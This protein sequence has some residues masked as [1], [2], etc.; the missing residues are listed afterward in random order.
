MAERRYW[1]NTVS[2]DHVQN[3]IDGGFTQA[4]HGAATRLRRLGG[5]DEIVFY[6]PRTRFRGGRPLQSFTAIGSIGAGAPYQVSMTD[7]FHP[8]R[9]PVRFLA[10][11]PDDIRP[12]I[13]Q[14]SFIADPL[15]WGMAFRRGLFP[16][17]EADFA[18]IATAMSALRPSS[19]GAADPLARAGPRLS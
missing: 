4:D 3:G 13:P 17:P 10:C 12:L 1:V 7:D 6:S 16:I 14:L 19:P 9:R 5:G 8:W 15:R 2:L 18:A 11:R